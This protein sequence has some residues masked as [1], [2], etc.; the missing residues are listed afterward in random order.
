[1]WAVHA[2]R[3]P[4]G[5]APAFRERYSGIFGERWEG[6]EEALGK[7]SLARSFEAWPGFP[8]YHLDAASVEAAAFLPLPGGEILD[9]CAAPGGKALVLASRMG[10]LDR[11]VA[12]ELSSDR[13]RRLSLVLDRHLEPG[14]RARVHV[15]GEDAA[16]MCRRNEGRFSAILLDAPC[17]SERHV[18]ADPGALEAWRPARVKSLALR[19]WALLSSAF[20]MLSEG[21]WLLYVTCSLG[22]EENDGVVGRLRQ[23]WGD[24]VA[25]DAPTGGAW[26]AGAFGS[27]LL[28]DRAG[29]QGPLY[30]ARL[31]K[32]PGS[33]P[34]ILDN[35]ISR[36]S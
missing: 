16:A 10:P 9:A 36:R 15:A 27:F 13:R 14:L 17:S 30:V 31:R 26:E 8:P 21:G 22:P 11:L 20:I 1:S 6:L 23:K 35:H 3:R 5:G 28:P 33:Q 2:S 12:N 32:L 19:Q 34:E 25:I 29:G 24:A 18:L 4:P 7:P